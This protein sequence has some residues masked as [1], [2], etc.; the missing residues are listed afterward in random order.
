MQ[1]LWHIIC[2]FKNFVCLCW[3]KSSFFCF[4]FVQLMQWFQQPKKL[5]MP[6]NAH[7]PSVMQCVL[8]LFRKKKCCQEWFCTVDYNATISIT[9]LKPKS[10]HGRFWTSTGTKKKSISCYNTT[11]LFIWFQKF[12]TNKKMYF[13]INALQTENRTISH[14]KLSKHCEAKSD[15]KKTSNPILPVRCWLKLSGVG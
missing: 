4:V 10:W 9:A 11:H 5:K 8:L 2:I 1:I 7:L 14:S 3:K 13:F 6:V 15:F 12:N